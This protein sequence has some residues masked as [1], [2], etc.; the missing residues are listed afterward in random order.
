MG[1]MSVAVPAYRYIR[2]VVREKAKNLTRSSEWGKVRSEHLKKFPQCAACGTK[3][4]LQVHHIKPFHIYPELELDP[5]NLIT[6]CMGAYECH[7]MIGHG[8]SWKCYN[9]DVLYD[10]KKFE[11]DA[12]ERRKIAESVKQ[13]RRIA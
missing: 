9:P 3:D 13:K 6:L 8:D 7:L 12:P 11:S 10:S 2:S 5:S 1:F 4:H